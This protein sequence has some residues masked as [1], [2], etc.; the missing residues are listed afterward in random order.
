MPMSYK[1]NAIVDR[2]SHNANRW[3]IYQIY[4]VSDLN[5]N[6]SHIHQ[7]SDLKLNLHISNIYIIKY[8]III[9]IF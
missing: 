2:T 9:K 6:A 7:I 4:V 5:K 3:F 8:K 1:F